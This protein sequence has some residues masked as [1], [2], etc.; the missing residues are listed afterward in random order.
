MSVSEVAAFSARV[1]V[2]VE[3]Q[4]YRSPSAVVA[5]SQSASR[6]LVLVVA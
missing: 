2:Q 1:T 5:A 6:F 4:L 3:D